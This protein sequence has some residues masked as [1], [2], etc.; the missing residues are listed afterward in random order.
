MGRKKPDFISLGNGEESRNILL[1]KLGTNITERFN[2]L[3]IEGEGS[4]CV[5]YNAILLSENRVGR[6]KEFYPLGLV[7]GFT[8]HADNM[9]EYTA[10]N[11]SEAEREKELFLKSHNKLKEIFMDKK[12]GSDISSF[13]PDF[14]V[15]ESCDMNGN[16]PEHPTLYIWTE[17]RKIT[18]FSDFIKQIHRDYDNLPEHKLFTLLS[19]M[20]TLT[21]RIGVLH[22]K[23]FL[24]LD[25]KPNNF[26]IPT[27][28]ENVLTDNIYLFDIN[29]LHS[30]YEDMVTEDL[31]TIGY[32]AP[33][34]RMQCNELI[35]RRS[36]VYSIGC[37]LFAAITGEI[38]GY[39]DKAYDNIERLIKESELITA[40][41][42]TNNIR[43]VELLCQLLKGLLIKQNDRRNYSC[44][45][46]VAALEQMRRLLLATEYNERINLKA[47]SEKLD[48]KPVKAEVLFLNHLYKHPLYEFSD[49]E[50]KE[51]TVLVAGFGN[52]GQRFLDCCLQIGQMHNK[53]LN[54]TVATQNSESEKALYLKNRPALQEFF[55]VD[56]SF[57][58][59]EK[60]KAY[61]NLY[62]KEVDFTTDF[63]KNDG[64]ALDLAE[65][66]PDYIF[67]SLGND[68]V[69]YNAAKSF[70]TVAQCAKPEGY[71][72]NYVLEKPIKNAENVGNAIILSKSVPRK[73][74]T[75]LNRMGLNAHLVWI[76]DSN[77]SYKD[78][79]KEFRK[80]YNYTSCIANV[81][82][83]KYKLKSIG[84]DCS[85][86]NE[87]ADIFC[88]KVLLNEDKT[89]FNEL[90]AV[91]HRR[92]VAEKICKGWTR[93]TNLQ[94]C[95]NGFINDEKAKKHVCLVRSTPERDEDIKKIKFDENFFDN[96]S[97][98]QIEKLDELDA[99]SVNLHRSL[100]K[101]ANKTRKNDVTLENYKT[102]LRNLI[103]G[104]R[105]VEYAYF[106]WCHC[107]ISLWNKEKG[108]VSK[109]KGLKKRL[110]TAIQ[111]EDENGNYLIR[112]A[113]QKKALEIINNIHLI[114]YPIVESLRYDDYKK[115]DEDLVQYIPFILTYK[116]NLDIVIPL[117]LSDSYNRY[118]KEVPVKDVF[119]NVA[120]I[121]IINPLKVC[122]VCCITEKNDIEQTRVLFK[123]IND[124]LVDGDYKT[125]VNVVIEWNKKN[126]TSS[127]DIQALKKELLQCDRI[128][129]VEVVEMDATEKIREAICSLSKVSAIQKLNG[130]INLSEIFIDNVNKIPS[131]SLD[132]E[133]QIHANEAC[134]FLN[135]IKS[136]KVLTVSDLFKISN[137]RGKNTEFP[138]FFDEYKGIFEI[139]LKNRGLWKTLCRVLGEN[140]SQAIEFG[141][142]KAETDCCSKRF[143]APVFAFD[144]LKKVE[145]FLKK[146][147]I[148]DNNSHVYRQHTDRCIVEL[149][150]VSQKC[151]YGFEKLFANI[152]YLCDEDSLLCYMKKTEAVIEAN[153]LMID[154]VSV[155]SLAGEN[156]GYKKNQIDFILNSL[157]AQHLITN[158]N[159]VDNSFSFCFTSQ[160][161]QQLLTKSG[162]ILE[163]YV[164]IACLKS[165]LFDD[166]ATSYE[167]NRDG[168][169]NDK[170]EFDIVLTRGFKSAFVECKTTNSLENNYYDKLHDLT[171][172]FGL[173]SKAILVADKY[174]KD[175]SVQKY[176]DE[177]LNY[178]KRKQILTVYDDAALNDIA[179]TLYDILK[180]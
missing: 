160:K 54:V 90:V 95:Y 7:D 13:I 81:V 169:E 82:S 53:K 111:A 131:F 128:K 119:A 144:A 40:T 157:N 79:R 70:S 66:A 140:S 172:E 133:F 141:G 153:D 51:I 29:T 5:C 179:K 161:S 91:E 130:L 147:N 125:K 97:I 62:F 4:S 78:V 105:L 60:E 75:E 180:E 46:I 86:L 178:G 156:F 64:I 126:I 42:S 168:N 84:I 14:T 99:L 118:T 112:K 17:N 137:A 18:L 127:A 139:Y 52:H 38:E 24:H 85:D 59:S 30:V 43:L 36:D 101:A 6:L 175:E 166:V 92:W 21:N 55:S 154:N 117:R 27:F 173:N 23:G 26:G 142:K 106:D 1:K 9:L 87:T 31:G 115:K 148:I 41:D 155:D 167:I 94:T 45:D 108:A 107:L 22:E 25:I 73:E 136:N 124:Y 65:K 57:Q 35:N 129:A 171:N 109:Y 116:H 89:N 16:A 138:E 143:Y 120:A 174:Q 49:N 104:K 158:I 176:P 32:S 56:D 37:L 159:W 114:Y 146:H 68:K 98:K 88:E 83:T 77:Y 67:V 12:E 123:K 76:Q 74:L 20:I 3:D 44:E 15:Y 134:N 162:A 110:E 72:V 58:E 163:M 8:R 28:K 177:I 145:V 48:K 102:Q 103:L 149:N 93:Q 151:I 121:T 33:E 170:N 96:A 50:A 69:N 165:G 80:T 63:Y 2:I 11:F 71:S 122:Y 152:Y 39:C 150:Q 10:S 113:D 34:V 100:K 19:T 47:V 61:G 135:Y 132:S 164:Y